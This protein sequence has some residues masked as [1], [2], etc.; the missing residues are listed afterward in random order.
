[1]RKNIELDT[2]EKIHERTSAAPHCQRDNSFPLTDFPY[3]RN[4]NSNVRQREAKVALVS[5]AEFLL[6]DHTE[7][8][9]VESCDKTRI[10]NT[11]RP[12]TGWRPEKIGPST[13]E[14]RPVG[15]KHQRRPHARPASA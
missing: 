10:A 5:V 14:R 4:E 12:D 3:A 1:M 8:D 7:Y 9:M 6:D 11:H 15:Q 2:V 13:S